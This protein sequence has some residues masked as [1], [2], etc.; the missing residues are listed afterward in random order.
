MTY[1]FAGHLHTQTL[2]FETTADRMSL[3]APVPGAIIPT[4][5]PRRWLAIVGSVGQPRDRSP[6]AAYAMFDTVRLE[7]TFHRV[8][9]DFQAAAAKIRAS[10]LPESLAYRVETG[11]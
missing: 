1:T 7:M 9:Y 10:G 11:V 6:A 3:F 8:A 2:Y 4:R 5:G